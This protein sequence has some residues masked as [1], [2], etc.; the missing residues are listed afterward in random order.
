MSGPDAGQ[1]GRTAP[2]L[3]G[4]VALITGAAHGQGR[5]AALALAREGVHIA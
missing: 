3:A 4:Q 5:A 1:S 2:E